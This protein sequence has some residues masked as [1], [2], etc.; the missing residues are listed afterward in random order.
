MVTDVKIHQIRDG[1]LNF[2]N[3]RITELNDL[4]TLL[5][6]QV[7]VLLTLVSLLELCNI[8][9][10]LMLNHQIAFQQQFNGII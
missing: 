9:S 4:A 5:T 10:K 6:N 1:I 3:A 2:L 7:V 8:L